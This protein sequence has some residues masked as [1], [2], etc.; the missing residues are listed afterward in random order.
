MLCRGL[1]TLDELNA[2]EEAE[3]VAIAAVPLSIG[4][5]DFPKIPLD[6]VEA[7]AF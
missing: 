5:F 7:A 3:R 1:K 4:D 6:L 2:I